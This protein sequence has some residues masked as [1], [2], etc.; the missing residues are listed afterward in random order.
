MV[1][2]MGLLWVTLCEWVLAEKLASLMDKLE[3]L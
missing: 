3:F 1:G 2:M